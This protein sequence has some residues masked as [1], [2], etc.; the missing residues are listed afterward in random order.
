MV[1]A[2]CGD[3]WALRRSACR[4]RN[5]HQPLGGYPMTILTTNNCSILFGLS[6]HFH[7]FRNRMW[8]LLVR[9]IQTNWLKGY[10]SRNN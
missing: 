4:D 5:G 3:G 2:P 1:L 8:C 9:Q 6:I 10:N 7:R